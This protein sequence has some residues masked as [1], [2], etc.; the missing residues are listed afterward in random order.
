MS[1]QPPDSLAQ[2][3]LRLRQFAQE[4][5]WGQFHAPKNLACALAVEAAELLEPFQWM[6]E[7][8]SSTLN[9]TQRA[10]VE[11]EMADVLLYLLQ[12]ANVLEVDLLQAAHAKMDLNAQRFAVDTPGAARVE[13][14][15]LS[16]RIPAGEPVR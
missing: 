15:G 16:E 10:H 11:Q 3:Q 6:S 2:L 9:A 5:G 7:A 13:C 4:R 8:Q 14:M 1:A 12:L